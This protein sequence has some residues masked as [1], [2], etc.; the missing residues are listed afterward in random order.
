MAFPGMPSDVRVHIHK[1]FLVF[2][3]DDDVAFRA[4]LPQ[5]RTVSAG[6]PRARQSAAPPLWPRARGQGIRRPNHK[7]DAGK[8]ELLEKA[9]VAVGKAVP[10]ENAA[11]EDDTIHSGQD[12]LELTVMLRNIACSYTQ[13]ELAHLLDEAGLAGTYSHMRL[14][15]NP[16]RNANLGYVFVT[17]TSRCHVQLYVEKLAGKTLGPRQ[18][19]K[20]LEVSLAHV[21]GEYTSKRGSRRRR[22]LAAASR[23]QDQG[24]LLLCDTQGAAADG[25]CS[26]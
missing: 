4:S 17:L 5:R 23:D 24:G 21:Q 2:T 11:V 19:A 13:V 16:V 20:K 15:R 14:P 8:P 3:S 10:L 9:L 25:K 26:F 18:T 12:A 6:P 22:A 7:A 1:T